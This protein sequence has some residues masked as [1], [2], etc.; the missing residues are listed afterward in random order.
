MYRKALIKG[1]K[2]GLPKFKI[3]HRANAKEVYK[4][5]LALTPSVDCMESI[6]LPCKIYE[7]IG[8]WTLFNMVMYKGNRVVNC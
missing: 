8:V 7:E 6:L 2:I 3:K 5:A 1:I 4:P